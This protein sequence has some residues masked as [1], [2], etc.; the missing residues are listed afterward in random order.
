MSHTW[1][2][3]ALRLADRY[4]DR[5][6]E[7]AT[8]HVVFNLVC[9]WVVPLSTTLKPLREV[10]DI[11]CHTGDFEYASYAAHAYVHNSI[12]AGRPLEPLLDESRD[13]TRRMRALGEVNALHVQVVF[14][15]VVMALTGA[16]VNDIALANELAARC[17]SD[18]EA[19]RRSLRAAR[20]GYSAWGASAK[21]AL[22]SAELSPTAAQPSP[23]AASRDRVDD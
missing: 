5:S 14:E 20:A 3:L 21:V 8:R 22:L 1:G 16:W 9:S 7:A 13:L 4:D 10:F 2:Q 11:G 19:K 12:Y 17:H 15:Q 23:M 18:P 6:L